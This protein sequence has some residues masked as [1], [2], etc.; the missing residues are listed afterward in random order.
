M[1]AAPI[2]VLIEQFEALPG[3]G[4][5]TAERLAFFVINMPKEKAEGMAKA[6]LNAKQQ[7]SFCSHCYNLTDR[8]P[9]AICSDPKRDQSTICVVEGPKDVTAIEKTR[10]FHG[11]YHVLHGVISPMDNVT[12]ADLKIKELYARLAREE[13]KEV[14][15][16]TNPTM[17]GEATA[18]YLARAIAPTG[19]TVSR[20]ASGIPIGGDLEYADEVT[21]AR[22]ISGRLTL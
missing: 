11:L 22:A 21:L 12:P 4:R 3:I 2:E 14:I 1:H 9:C 10:E 17:E 16:A 8:D 20:I 15:I 19:I 6:I 7:I 18:M 5:K 13:V